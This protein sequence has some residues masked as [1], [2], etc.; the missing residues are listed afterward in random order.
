MKDLEENFSSIMQIIRMPGWKI[1]EEFINS[2]IEERG[3][4]L[5]LRLD[6]TERQ[7]SF[8]QGEISGL[9]MFTNIINNITEKKQLDVKL[10]ET[11]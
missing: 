10:K 7:I 5:I 1:I 9:G 3:K 4:E 11:K 8:I 2:Q 6:I